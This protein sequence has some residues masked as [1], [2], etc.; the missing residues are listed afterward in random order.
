MISVNL[1]LW[2]N[3]KKVEYEQKNVIID[4]LWSVDKIRRMTDEDLKNKWE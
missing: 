1:K 2:K 4:V 3:I